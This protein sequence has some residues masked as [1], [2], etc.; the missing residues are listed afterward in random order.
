MDHSSVRIGGLAS[1]PAGWWRRAFAWLRPFLPVVPLREALLLTALTAGV[2]AV[3]FLGFTRMFSEPRIDAA[4]RHL[5]AEFGALAEAYDRLPEV[6]REAFLDAVV[7]GGRGR[8]ARDDPLPWGLVEPADEATAVVLH[9]MRNLLPVGRVGLT[10]GPGGQQ[11]WLALPA[12]GGGWTWLRVSVP[13]RP[14]DWRAA[15]LVSL[16]LLVAV[17][18]LGSAFLAWRLRHRVGWMRRELEHLETAGAGLA[19]AKGPRTAALA[20]DDP[21]P[22][23]SALAA[24][25]AQAS[26]ERASLAVAV[27]SDLRHGLVRLAGSEPSLASPQAAQGVAR[28]EDALARLDAVAA[29][30]TPEKRSGAGAP[31]LRASRA[32]PPWRSLVGDVVM[33]TALFVLAIALGGLVV[34]R[35]VASPRAQSAA[36]TMDVVVTGIQASYRALPAEHRAA[37]LK[38][39]SLYGGGAVQV[40]DPARWTI[41]PPRLWLAQ[42]AVESLRQR[43]PDLPILI[44][45]FPDSFLWVQ[46]EDGDGRRQWIRFSSPVFVPMQGVALGALGLLL[47]AAAALV[48]ARARQRLAWFSRTIDA[49]DPLVAPAPADD[50]ETGAVDPAMQAMRRSIQRAAGALARGRD[51]EELGL[52]LLGEALAEALAA[53]REAIPRAAEAAGT[54]ECLEAMARRVAQL[55]LFAARRQDAGELATDINGEL[56]ALRPLLSGG[57]GPPLLWTFGG[58][59]LADIPA[60]EARR[61]FLYL[62]DEVVRHGDAPIEISTSLEA[63]RIVVRIAGHAHGPAEPAGEQDAAGQALAARIAEANG[64]LVRLTTGPDGG[65]VAQAWLRPARVG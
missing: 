2:F 22:H 52:A 45:P 47:V 42:K 5:S 55:D 32:S 56:G 10:K 25:L 29:A 44:T 7:A 11:I 13:S 51:K 34:T 62:L 8:I 31:A 15:V 1:D 48:V 54:A 9:R 60:A 14:A 58:L 40:D 43:R 35:V 23:L 28:L 12:R 46:L 21:Q 50:E 39:L 16:A 18:A 20:A 17:G 65:R 38:A 53:L 19:S 57:D 61:L 59:P 33:V 36:E 4:G 41:A 37:Y 64:G 26:R 3:A 49:A 6:Q 24:R 30:A 27:A 63:S